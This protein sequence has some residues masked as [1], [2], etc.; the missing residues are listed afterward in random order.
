M[1]ASLQAGTGLS[2]PVTIA[3]RGPLPADAAGAEPDVFN[4]RLDDAGGWPLTAP[5]PLDT[6]EQAF[7]PGRVPAAGVAGGGGRAAGGAPG[8]RWCPA[9][10]VRR[11]TGRTPLVLG[12]GGRAGDLA[13]AGG[14][15]RPA[16]AG[17]LDLHRCTARRR[18][19]CGS[20]RAWWPA[21]SARARRVPVAR[22]GRAGAGGACTWRPAATTSAPAASAA[23]TGSTTGCRSTRRSCSPAAPRTVAADAQ[24]PFSAGRGAR[25]QPDQL[26]AD[27]AEGGAAG[28]DGGRARAVREPGGRLEHRRVAR[29]CRPGA[30]GW[31]CRPPTPPDMTDVSAPPDPAGGGQTRPHPPRTARRRRLV[32]RFRH[33]RQR[34]HRHPGRHPGGRSGGAGAA[35]QR[36]GRGTGLPGRA[37]RRPTHRGP[38]RR[39]TTLRVPR[40]RRRREADR[41]A[42]AGPAGDARSR[43]PAP[44]GAGDAGGWRGP[45]ARRLPAVRDGQLLLA[46]ASS[47][48]PRGAGGGD[49]RAPDRHAGHTAALATGL[50][51][52]AAVA[53]MRGRVA[54][55]GV[56]GRR[57]RAAGHRVGLG[58][59][60]RRRRRRPAR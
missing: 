24:V 8:R 60:G 30:T 6:L 25:G 57:G 41:R 29:L 45:R 42:G 34:L 10:A 13:G 55:L 40:R 22:D 16:R 53:G 50:A 33:R 51:P 15:R 2:V 1:R 21:S 48:V 18:P 39:R 27:A 23:T 37:R 56:A 35:G 4:A 5:G 59:R 17:R 31:T 43:S 38:T 47:A 26:R 12:A 32:G 49:A 9:A 58:V 7:A 54:R 44:S 20:A 3:V 28:R 52:V 11:A 36:S 14:P 46:T 19:A